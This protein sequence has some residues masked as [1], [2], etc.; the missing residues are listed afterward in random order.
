[1][2]DPSPASLEDAT[3]LAAGLPL[4]QM[5]TVREQTDENGRLLLEDAAPKSARRRAH[6]AGVAMDTVSC[7]YKD[8]PSRYGGAMNVS[9]YEALRADMAEVFDGFA[10]LTGNYLDLHQGRKSTV[11]GLFDCSYLGLT[12]PLVLFYRGRDPVPPHRR[13]PSFVASMF[14][15]SRGVFS[16]A[17]DMLNR[18]GPATRTSAAEVVRFAEEQGHLIRPQTRRACA[19]PTR[20][21]ERTLGVILTGEGG[22]ATRTVLGEMV[23]FRRLWD[24]YTLQDSFSRAVSNY[25]FLLDDVASQTGARDPAEMFDV[26][27]PEGGKVRSL[28]EV[29]DRVVGQANEIQR[30]LN[31]VLERADDAPVISFEDLLGML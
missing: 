18:Q 9:A 3:P 19:A 4:A 5:L 29:T 20:L 31:A 8:T 26:M 30:G 27:V 23:D 12:L 21:I 11:R 2:Q 13:L 24:F 25:R 7:P 10:W 15:A 1:M 6:K 22:D 17:V 28:G 14:K 16:A